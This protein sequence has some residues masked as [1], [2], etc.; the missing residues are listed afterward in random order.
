M[1]VMR[2]CDSVLVPEKRVR[3]IV[4]CKERFEGLT[5]VSLTVNGNEVVLEGDSFN[6][7]KAKRII[8][9]MARGFGFGKASLL[10]RDGFD[11]LVLDVS[12]FGNTPNRRRVLKGRVIGRGGAVKRFIERRSGVSVVVFGDTVSVVGEFDAVEVAGRAIVALLNGCKIGTAFRVLS[13]CK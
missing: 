4:G 3:V 12:D 11:L 1:R 13:G 7:F 5:G 6:V 9:A 8:L 10:W 2:V